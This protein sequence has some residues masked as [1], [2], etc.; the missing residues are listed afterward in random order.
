MQTRAWSSGTS[1]LRITGGAGPWPA[2]FVH[3]V[4]T[5]R[6]P[7]FF[8]YRRDLPHWRLSSAIYF[9]TFRVRRPQRDLGF[10]E[11]SVVAEIIRRRI[12]QDYLLDAFV[13]MNDHVHAVL[14]P[15]GRARLEEIVGAWKSVSAIELRRRG[16]RS[17]PLW[18]RES[19][20]RILR[21]EEEWL[22]K[23]EYILQNPIRRW[24]ELTGYVWVFPRL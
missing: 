9:V 11:R 17:A 13:V 4:P 10:E 22:E 12:G 16:L 1:I 2:Q 18:Q 24:P 5:M 15:L 19:F 3:L 21:N 14:Q 7:D 6:D 8:I 20:D 23:V